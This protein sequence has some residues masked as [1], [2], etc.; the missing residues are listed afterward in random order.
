MIYGRLYVSLYDG[1]FA[2]L[3]FE[4]YAFFQLDLGINTD[5]EASTMLSKNVFIYLILLTIC[6]RSRLTVR[7]S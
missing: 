2:I 6:Q 3:D 5:R 7:W 1:H 4:L